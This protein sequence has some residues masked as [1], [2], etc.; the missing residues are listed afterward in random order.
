MQNTPYNTAILAAQA[1]E[2]IRALIADIED[3]PVYECGQ[4]HV[5]DALLEARTYANE[6]TAI[7]LNAATQPVQ[8][9]QIAA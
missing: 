8:P 5:T 9:V 6:I 4:N 3:R 7:A 1:A 2:A